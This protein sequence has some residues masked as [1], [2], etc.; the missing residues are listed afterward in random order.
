MIWT[1]WLLPLQSRSVRRLKNRL[2]KTIQQ[3]AEVCEPRCLLSAGTVGGSIAGMKFLD[4]NSNG[5]FDDGDSPLTNWTVFLDANGNGQ[6]DLAQAAVAAS[7]V[8]VP[9]E[10]H[11]R[12]MSQINVSGL[13]GTIVDIDVSFDIEHTFIGD[14]HGFLL[15]PTG[16]S[17]ELFNHIGGAA[18]GFTQTTLDDE[19]EVSIN[20]PLAIAPYT[21]SF[22]PLDSISTFDGKSPNGPWIL[23]IHDDADGDEGRITS[24]SLS[25]S[26][27]GGSSEQFAVTNK[28][29]NYRFEEL[30]PGTYIVTEA[31][32]AGFRQTF[33]ID[34]LPIGTHSIE[35]SENEV[36]TGVDFGNFALPSTIRGQ[37]W[38]DRNGDGFKA[39]DEVG[40]NG[41]TIELLDAETNEVLRSTLSANVDLNHDQRIDPITEAGIYAFE[42]LVPG[43]YL[44]REVMQ[45]G[46]V[47]TFPDANT[48]VLPLHPVIQEPTFTINTP[49]TGTAEAPAQWLPD[50]TVDLQNPGGLRDAFLVGDVLR[51]GQATPNV[52][53]GPLRIV[54]GEDNGD[55]TQKVYQRIYNDQGG[56]IE[57]EAGDFSFHPAHNHIHFNGFARYALRAALSDSS[58]DGIPEVGD[59]IRGG[60]KTSFCLVDVAR[61]S[62]TPPLPNDDPQGSGLGCDTQ[63]E[64]SVGWEDIY[65]AGTEGQ[66]INVAG[67]ELGDYWLEATVDPDNHFT[68]LN[69]ENNT[70]RILIHIGPSDRVHDVLLPPDRL[71]DQQDFGNFHKI[72]IFGNVFQD[73]NA[74]GARNDGEEGL[75]HTV[76]FI[77]LNG[78][79]LLNNPTSGN[80]VADGLALEPWAIA[81]ST[82]QFVFHD[83]GP[84]DYLIRTVAPHGT[85]QTSDTATV[86]AFSG[87]NIAD[88]EF[89]IGI[90][91][92]AT[93]RIST[94]GSQL[95]IDDIASGGK[96]DNLTVELVNVIKAGQ[97]FSQVRITDPDYELTTSIGAQEGLHTVYLSLDDVARLTSLIIHANGGNDHVVVNTL[98]SFAKTIVY[99]GDG[100]DD[101][102]LQ[103]G[104]LPADV[105]VPSSELRE[106]FV[107]LF[108]PELFGDAGDD[109]LTGAFGND[110]IH[111][112]SGDDLIVGDFGDD[113][114]FGESGNDL[115][116]GGYGDD[117]IL[118]GDGN[119]TLSGESGNDLLAGDRGIDQVFGGEGFNDISWRDGDGLEPLGHSDE[120]DFVHLSASDAADALTVVAGPRGHTLVR[121]TNR[122]AFTLD[123]INIMGLEIFGAGGND[124]LT[125][126][127]GPDLLTNRLTPSL[128]GSVPLIFDGGSGRDLWQ[129]NGSQQA[130]RVVLVDSGFDLNALLPEAR[131]LEVG[132]GT[133]QIQA[134][135]SSG[136]DLF[137]ASRIT[138]A[139]VRIVVS[140]GVGNDTL[141]GGAGVVVFSGDDGNDR[142][143]GGDQA[144][145]LTGGKGDDAV[146][147]GAG[148]DTL[149]GNA[150]NDSLLG[151][152]GADS[153]LGAAGDDKI[154][155]GNGNDILI[156]GD[157]NDTLCGDDGD[158]SLVGQA[159]ND[160][161]IGGNGNDSVRGD[162]G[163]DILLGL[164]DNDSLAGGN[165]N[166]T[167]L[168]GDGNDKLS[169]QDGKDWL[170]GEA[171]DDTLFG[172]DGSDHL[173]GGI[174]DNDVLKLTSP[175]DLIG[176]FSFPISRLLDLC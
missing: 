173:F 165:G 169:G 82:G 142:L 172:G 118:G 175:R 25:F 29:G 155:G 3:S 113:Q 26:L 129:L 114:L 27:A 166:D 30:A 119:D 9:I 84:G 117:K 143:V 109:T 19:A 1:N 13:A 55:G 65:G 170:L 5:S 120:Q 75:A 10:D 153:I 128:P 40:S 12:G 147:G 162:D 79:H 152:E 97:F 64:I 161:L 81:D 38:D 141:L 85:V 11:D 22:R 151:S 31:Q 156:G 176:V 102:R 112:G 18:H 16:Q 59:V 94:D 104:F 23:E 67:L 57:R 121:R 39:N 107:D 123:L 115:I 76:V 20:S 34:G 101:L 167:L 127:F 51:F 150:G 134:A 15:G 33:P 146:D 37:T 43:H 87:M 163:D 68:E 160:V 32:Q 98:F 136:N 4:A 125:T 6:L 138:N 103:S 168:G 158:D 137:D 174:G 95:T 54:G 139:S 171:G 48:S 24:F 66:E 61:F 88:L 157:G 42:N 41:W 21:G 89:G 132:A 110:L 62:T 60:Q 122:S 105:L 45:T 71:V 78:D 145:L 58:G 154:H 135:L 124:T 69:E 46:W 73:S 93:T 36:V 74:N 56:Y 96:A 164:A 63:Q 50:L 47:A 144:D 106:I 140:G 80:G 99:G 17:I 7:D 149:N 14:L 92:N 148:N 133:E 44:L 90:V 28:S 52:G 53:D 2:T 108:A 70:G 100:N 77:D 35:L 91:R 131:T 8:P 126:T 116:F 49:P 111:G 83:F 159:G 72:D 130:D 86:S